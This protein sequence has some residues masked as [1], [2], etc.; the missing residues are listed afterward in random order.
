MESSNS[1]TLGDSQS[2][3]S[4]EGQQSTATV[5]KCG[6]VACNGC[7]NCGNS[8]LSAIQ[9]SHARKKTNAGLGNFCSYLC[10]KLFV[11]TG[12]IGDFFLAEFEA[13]EPIQ[14]L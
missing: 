12:H 7:G 14:I 4:C 11:N 6:N 1:V 9:A 10:T 8:S 5:S 13:A 2:K 3:S